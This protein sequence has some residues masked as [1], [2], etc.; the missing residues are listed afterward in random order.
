M[1]TQLVSRAF[2]IAALAAVGCASTEITST[3]TAPSA[4]GS[5]LSRVAVICMVKD[6][7]IRRMAEDAAAAELAG[8]QATPS[9]QVLGDVNVQD[10]QAVNEKLEALGFQAV[11]VM[12]VAGV[13]EQVTP[14][15][16]PG[17]AFVGYYGW[18]APMVWGP[19]YVQTQ[20]IVHMVTNLYSMREEGRLI[21]SGA[22]KTFDPA[23]LQAVAAGVAKA[24]GKE[25][26]K[27]HILAG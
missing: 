27:Q 21:W 20:T 7:G 17:P 23:S 1:K 22:S 4:P 3:W 25:L 19:A 14:V 11:L 9:Y 8:A 10:A 2:L 16:A 26:K 13:N 5:A 24:V 12:R 18:A 6:E 15:A